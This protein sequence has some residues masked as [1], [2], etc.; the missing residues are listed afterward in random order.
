M[1]RD[2]LQLLERARSGERSAFREIVE[3]HQANVYH[4]ALGLLARPE[5]AEDVAQEVFVRAY[6]SLDRFRGEA[7][8]D[9][10]LY[11]ITLNASRDHQRRARW[12]AFQES[13]PIAAYAELWRDPRADAD[14]ER[15]ASS[16]QVREDVEQALGSLSAAERRV[17]VLRHLRQLSV[18]ETAEVLGRAEG[19][20]KNLLFRALRKLRRQLAGHRPSEASS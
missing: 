19:T 1:S 16:K 4:L 7:A 13:L 12:Q 8:L 17:F 11:R 20:V 15:R 14:P 18:R 6:R 2:D 3:R 10:W 9:T 5:D